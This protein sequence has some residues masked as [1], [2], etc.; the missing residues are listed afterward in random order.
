MDKIIFK[1]TL[2]KNGPSK[3]ITIPPELL[4]YLELDQIGDEVHLLAS[5]GKHGKYIAIYNPKN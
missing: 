2:S 1:R 3:G 4:T 5:K